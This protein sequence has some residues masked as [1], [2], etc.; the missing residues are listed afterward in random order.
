M[1]ALEWCIIKLGKIAPRCV[2]L[3]SPF[4]VAHDSLFVAFSRAFLEGSHP[5]VAYNVGSLGRCHK[6]QADPAS[7][8]H[9]CA[10]A[11]FDVPD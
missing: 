8:S 11:F 2:Q 5:L 10:D 6:V 1:H 4:T 7:G 3:R 9:G